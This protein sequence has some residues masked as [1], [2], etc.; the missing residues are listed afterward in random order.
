MSLR[1]WVWRIPGVRLGVILEASPGDTFMIVLWLGWWAFRVGYDLDPKLTVIENPKPDT[2][3]RPDR[4]PYVWALNY[5]GGCMKAHYDPVT[6]EMDEHP[7]HVDNV[8]RCEQ[9]GD[10]PHHTTL[11]SRSGPDR[12]G[13]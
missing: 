10:H 9:P 12:T 8:N 11:R 13:S 5:G 6:G 3:R 1:A 7:Y 4:R 2:E